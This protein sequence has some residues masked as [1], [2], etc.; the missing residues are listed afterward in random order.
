[1]DLNIL[2]E[3]SVMRAQIHIA[4]VPMVMVMHMKDFIE[5]NE[6]KVIL[7]GGR[8]MKVQVGMTMLMVII[9]TIKTHTNTITTTDRKG[10]IVE[11]TTMM[12]TS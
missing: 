5:T 4:K 3:T 12:T 9:T 1:M 2:V 7:E 11:T 6:Q 8:S 10:E